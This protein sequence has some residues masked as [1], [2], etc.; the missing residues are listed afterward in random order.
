M[1]IGILTLV[2][3]HSEMLH[4]SANRVAIFEDKKYKVYM[5][6]KYKI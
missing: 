4:K 3:I 5:N 2:Y 1:H 6:E